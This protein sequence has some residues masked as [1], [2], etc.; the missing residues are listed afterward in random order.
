MSSD[1]CEFRD[2]LLDEC[3]KNG[4]VSGGDFLSQPIPQGAVCVNTVL[5]YV[6]QYDPALTPMEEGKVYDMEPILESIHS[7]QSRP[8]RQRRV[9]NYKQLHNA[10]FNNKQ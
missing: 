9:H 2:G 7:N 3:D 6:N 5:D 1:G 4:E 8:T 10:G